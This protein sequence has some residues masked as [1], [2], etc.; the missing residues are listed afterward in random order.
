MIV[1]ILNEAYES[2]WS[3]LYC[4]VIQ[5]ILKQRAEH[6][7]IIPLLKIFR[8]AKSRYIFG[9]SY[10]LYIVDTFT[11]LYPLVCWQLYLVVSQLDKLKRNTMK[12]TQINFTNFMCTDTI[13]DIKLIKLNSWWYLFLFLGFHMWVI[14]Q[15]ILHQFSRSTWKNIPYLSPNY[16]KQI[17]HIWFLLSLSNN[18]QSFTLVKTSVLRFTFSATTS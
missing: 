15:N 2:S 17:G 3:G 11:K 7:K 4:V 10:S 8:K 12:L 13:V 5:N 16:C 14:T 9:L 6:E 18:N 1:L